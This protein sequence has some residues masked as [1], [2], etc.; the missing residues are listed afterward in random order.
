MFRV[1]LLLLFTVSL[2]FS[3]EVSNQSMIMMQTRL[4]GLLE[5]DK[6]SCLRVNGDLIIWSYGT[7]LKNNLIYD[8]NNKP[9]AEI[10]KRVIFGG[11]GFSSNEGGAEALKNIEKASNDL[12]SKRC[13]EPYFFVNSVM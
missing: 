11:G 4:S 9:I 7:T 1:I 2:L 5:E 12:P 10:G 8:K 6:N 13:A 3:L